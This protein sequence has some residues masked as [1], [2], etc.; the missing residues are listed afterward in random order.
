MTARLRHRSSKT[1][2]VGIAMTLI[3]TI[4]LS[5]ALTLLLGPF[6][7]ARTTLLLSYG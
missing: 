6:E 5:L 2:Q 7:L 4:L 1:E 3:V